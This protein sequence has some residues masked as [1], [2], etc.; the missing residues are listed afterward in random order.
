MHYGTFGLFFTFWTPILV[1]SAGS[2]RERPV[3]RY[4]LEPLPGGFETY[5]SVLAGSLRLRRPTGYALG[6][7]FGLRVRPESDIESSSFPPSLPPFLSY[8]FVGFR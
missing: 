1:G 3:V 4:R 2:A 6:S 8:D 5:F 7:N